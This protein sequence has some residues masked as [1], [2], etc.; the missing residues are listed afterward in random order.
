LTV[1][2]WALALSAV[3]TVPRTALKANV[4]PRVV[5]IIICLRLGEFTNTYK[6]A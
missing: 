2:V 1:R 3:K 6:V 4:V 5:L